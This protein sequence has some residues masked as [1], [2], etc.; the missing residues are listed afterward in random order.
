MGEPT[1]TYNM[2]Y[3]AAVGIQQHREGAIEK[4]T[5]TAG[6]IV[7]T[8]ILGAA[9]KSVATAPRAVSYTHLDFTE[10]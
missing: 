8:L 10:S 6:A 2:I 5:K 7:A 3:R 4:A 1:S 9:L